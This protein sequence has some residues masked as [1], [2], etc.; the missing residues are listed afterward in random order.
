[1][2]S[3]EETPSFRARESARRSSGSRRMVVRRFD[4]IQAIYIIQASMEN[5]AK[6]R[7]ARFRRL[8]P[9]SRSN[10]PRCQT[11]AGVCNPRRAGRRM[12]PVARA[13]RSPLI[14]STVMAAATTAI[15][16]RSMTPMARRI[17]MRP[18]MQWR[19]RPCHHAMPASVGS[20]R[21]RPGCAAAGT[22]L[23]TKS[24]GMFG[25]P[26]AW[27]AVLSLAILLASA[28]VTWAASNGP[29]DP[30]FG[31]NVPANVAAAVQRITRPLE[32][33]DLPPLPDNPLDTLIAAVNAHSAS[34]GFPVDHGP[35]LRGSGIPLEFAGRLALLMKA[36]L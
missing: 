6:D 8:A 14:R 11:A 30:T 24:K 27:S 5:G 33:V 32:S 18:I 36:V 3:D 9:A 29:V 23:A 26:G 4:A 10:F 12:A 2:S 25:S 13:T 35:V 7:S 21:P 17:A 28:D 16:Q 20:V 31:G 1:M 34:L 22:R 19:R 15:A